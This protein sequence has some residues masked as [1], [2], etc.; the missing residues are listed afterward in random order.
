MIRLIQVNSKVN[1]NAFQYDG[2]RPLQWPSGVRGCLPRWGV[3]P[4]GAWPGSVCLRGVCPKRVSAQM[5]V[6]CLGN[7]SAQGESA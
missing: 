7:V 4:G 5:G 3:C 2:Y 6:V 1:K